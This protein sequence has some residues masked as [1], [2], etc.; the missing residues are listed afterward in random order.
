MLLETYTHA[1]ATMPNALRYSITLD[2]RRKTSSDRLSEGGSARASWIPDARHSER[3]SPVS[4]GW[5]RI[6]WPF[7]AFLLTKWQFQD[8]TYRWTLQPQPAPLF[9]EAVTRRWDSKGNYG[10]DG[11]FS[12]AWEYTWTDDWDPLSDYFGWYTGDIKLL[13]RPIPLGFTLNSLIAAPLWIAVL[14]APGWTRRFI[15]KRR[16]KCTA[17]GYDIT[18]LATCPECGTARK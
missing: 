15:R 13:Y 3:V 2:P 10:R 14:F 5:T 6:G 9:A 12:T 18:Q 11:Q 17:C 16:G 1:H 7:R 4:F 8:S